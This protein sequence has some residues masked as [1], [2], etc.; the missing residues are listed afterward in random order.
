MIDFQNKLL[1]KLKPESIQAGLAVVRE[2]L[3][4]NEYVIDS[5]VSFRD[6]VV[7][8]NKRVISV[9]VQGISG[10]KVDY[11]SMPY[12][13]IQAYSVETSGTFD[14]DAELEIWISQVGKVRFEIKGS[15]NI[16]KLCKTIS[17]L[18]LN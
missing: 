12:N 7:F 15:A 3:I 5:Y 9:N 1:F 14:L 16:V 10:K 17:E 8:T 11:T 13:K 6:R 18:I 2:L 4:E